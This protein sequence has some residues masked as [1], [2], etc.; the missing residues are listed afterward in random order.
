MNCIHIC[1]IEGNLKIM[2]KIFFLIKE[3][4]ER[5]KIKT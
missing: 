3:K 4:N 2:E 1:A 5:Y